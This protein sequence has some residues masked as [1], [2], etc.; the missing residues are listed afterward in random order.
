M[1]DELKQ[2]FRAMASGAQNLAIAYIGVVNALFPALRRLGAVAPERLADEAGMD[3]GY[4]RR[5]CDAAYA[6]GYLEAEGETFR[7]GESGLAM[8]ADAPDTLMPLAAQ[9]VLNVHMAE[10]AAGLMRSGARPGEKVMAEGETLLPW[11]GPM[12][13]ASFAGFFENTIC[14]AL[15]IFAEIDARGGLVVDLGCGNGW[16]L[17]ALARR[18]RQLRGLGLD[19]FQEN[20]AQSARLAEAEGSGG[21]LR[22]AS[23]DA[24][25]FTLDEPADAIAM[26]RALHHVWEARGGDLIRR[27]RDALRPGG[28][29]VI[30]EPDWPA[31]APTCASPSA[32]AWRS[33]TSPNM[34]R[35]SSVARRRN[36]RGFRRR[37]HGARNP[38]FR[39]RAG[40]PHRRPQGRRGLSDGSARVDRLRLRIDQSGQLAEIG[41]P[42]LRQGR[43]GRLLQA[44]DLLV[45]EKATPASVEVRHTSSAFFNSCCGP[46]AA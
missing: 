32:A 4:V 27:L 2:K 17:R 3:A 18:Y 10:R 23:G 22:F 5:W 42:H 31:D 21:R 39:R 43:L 7:L 34:S 11:F 1:S 35:A 14:P 19:G 41:Q 25:A 37:G 6:F 36:R 24:L 26:S 12:L 15:P 38:S 13:E 9:V 20:V 45:A 30:W 46:A 44:G 33:R 29:A 28:A 8:L 16:Y 40:S